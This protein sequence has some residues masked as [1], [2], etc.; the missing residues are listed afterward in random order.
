MITIGLVVEGTHDYLM[1]EPLIAYEISQRFGKSVQFRYLQ[2]A[3]DA[4]AGFGGGGWH[5]VMA[6]CGANAGPQLATY[7]TPLFADDTPCDAIV[8]HLDGDSLEL[9]GIDTPADP[10]PV[11]KRVELIS[12]AISEWLRAE[13]NF[14]HKIAHAIPVLQTE[15]WILGAEG[16]KYEHANAKDEFRKSY[17][18][19]ADGPVR[20]FYRRRASS[21]SLKL[22]DIC[23]F[24]ESYVHFQKSISS[25]TP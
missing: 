1:L 22:G 9:A 7:F 18:L 24:C 4:T 11:T 20:N 8:I 3:P 14:K 10:I 12:T 2:P 6:W 25:L 23:N 21:P 13:E 19:P 16:I 15:A 17:N 5:R